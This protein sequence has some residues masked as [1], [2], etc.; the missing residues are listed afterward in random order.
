MNYLIMTDW[1]CCWATLREPGVSVSGT[2]KRLPFFA[3]IISA[4]SLPAIPAVAQSNSASPLGT[5]LNGVTYYTSEQPFLN[6]FKTGGGWTTGLANITS[7]THEEVILYQNCLDANGNPTVV[8]RCANATFNQVGVTLFMG[9]NSSDVASPTYQ[10]GDYLLQ[11]SGTGN[12]FYMF[13]PGNGTCA[14]SPCVIHV[15]S[16]SSNGI[17]LTLTSTGTPPNNVQNISLIYCGTWNGTHCSATNSAGVPYDTLLANGE[18]FN[19]AFIN[20]IKPFK[21]LRFMDWMA[22]MQNFQT[23]WTDRP[24]ASWVFWDDSRTNATINGADPRVLNDGVPAEVMFALCNEVQADCWFNMPP[25]AT[26]DYVT[27]FAT[28]A[29]STLN[30]NLK[31]YVEYAN[32]IWNP[33]YSCFAQQQSGNT[34]SPL[35]HAS[36]WQQ[37][38][39]QGHAAY[40]G[41]AGNDWM[42]AFQYGEAF[43]PV[44]VGHDWKVAW[45][46]DSGR[47]IRV[48]AG[49]NGYTYMNQIIL[50]SLP[51]GTSVNT[52]GSSLGGPAYWYGTTGGTVA[53]NVDA[54]AVAPYFGYAVP[55]TLTLDQLFTEIM[56]GGVVS[57]GYPGGMIA[58]TLAWAATNY[59][60]AQAAGLP[61]I[62][63]EG[64]QTLIDTTYSDTTLQALYAAANRD[65]RMGIAYSTYLNGWKALGG[66]VFNNFIDIEQYSKYGYWGALENYQDTSSPKYSALT[67]FISS[68]PCWWSGCAT[69][70]T[71]VTATPAVATTTPPSVPTGL[72]GAVA[73]A[74]QINLTWT[75]STDSA[76]V[77][78]GYNVSRNGTK[79][80][81]PNTTSYSDT[82]LLAGTAYTYTV[83]AYDKAGNT[84]AQSSSISVSTPAPP[85]VTISSP[86][87]GAVIKGYGNINIAAT[88]SDPN[89]VQ[90][91]TIKGNS[92]TLLTCTSTTSCSTTWPASTLSRGTHVI[93]VTATD[94]FGLQS[95]ASV[96]VVDLR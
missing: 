74:T 93:S 16:P 51:N 25:L 13:D 9:L 34:S 27:Q 5:N 96:T 28:L 71:S 80:G 1:L 62:A 65:P 72:A 19:P 58:Q 4:L 29:H 85:K 55:D 54:L 79:V 3:V 15:S 90:T 47:V 73:S 48:A 12:W 43:R 39:A 59:S 11:W 75:A 82:G 61:M 7:D 36:V 88:A 52:G 33:C 60:F 84:S 42:A 6:I 68:N 77:L 21:T 37:L 38:V 56:T 95:S 89:G 86:S 63:Y 92:T 23:N 10:A 26:D 87:N 8:S 81:T 94:K 30:S 64:G 50:T 20:L 45:G 31:V 17:N 22:T 32:E 53:Q 78:A 83:S 67:G 46:T 66:T 2:L 18:L 40:P 24:Q 35:N 57:G 70:G 69:S 76:G 44:Q 41:L 14:T 91:I 49:W